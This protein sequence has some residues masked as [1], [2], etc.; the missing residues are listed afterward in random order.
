MPMKRS[1]YPKEWPAISLRIRER[2][3]W[4]CEWCGVPNGAIGARD[5]HGVWHNENDIHHMNS[6]CGY[7]LFGKFPKMIKIVLTVAHIGPDKHNKM[8]CRDEVL[9]ALCQR[10]HFSYDLEDHIAH[11]KETRQ[12]KKEE[13]IKQSG[14][15]PLL[16]VQ[17]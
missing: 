16:V 14:Q 3:Q 9:A 15:L 4:R 2:A 8:D 13:A 5:K 1:L 17:T 6:D 10:C 12:R 11:A 7:E